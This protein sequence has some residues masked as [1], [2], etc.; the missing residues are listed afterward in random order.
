[1]HVADAGHHTP[2]VHQDEVVRHPVPKI[3]LIFNHSVKQ[4]SDLDLLTLKLVQMSP[5]TWTTFLPVNFGVLRLF[6]VKL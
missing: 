5:T 4:P 2:L 3:W 1:M 6:V